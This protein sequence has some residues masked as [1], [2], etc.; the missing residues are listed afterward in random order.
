MPLGSGPLETQ[1]TL[2]LEKL[3]LNAG[4]NR[5]DSITHSGDAVEFMLGW[6]AGHAAWCVV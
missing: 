2:R 1:Q 5:T 4:L 3:A 6:N